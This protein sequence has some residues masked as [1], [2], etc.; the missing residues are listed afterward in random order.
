MSEL[1][2]L[3]DP[4]DPALAGEFGAEERAVYGY[5]HSRIDDP[6]TAIEVEEHIA[7]ETGERKA[8]SMRRLR[9][10]RRWFVIPATRRPGQSPVYPLVGLL[11]PE[12]RRPKREALSSRVEAELYAAYNNRCAMCGKSPAEDNVKLVIDHKLPVEWGGETVF[13]NLQ[14]LCEYHNHGKQAWVSSL[15]PNA[16]AI[17]VS[18]SL[19]EPQLRI[20]E[21][22]KALA[23][24]PV[25]AELIAV[26]AREENSGDPLRRLRDLRTLGWKIRASRKKEGKRTRSYYTLVSWESWPIEGPQAAVAA[27]ESRRRSGK[28]KAVGSDA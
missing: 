10:L 13:E 5:L 14:P 28:S 1:L 7:A 3:L 19:P 16:D 22:L 9:E 20:G 25:P 2:E 24:E 17:R 26:V 27:I 11:P 23:G 8:Q 12:K 15:D 4:D 18:I 21:M 6:P